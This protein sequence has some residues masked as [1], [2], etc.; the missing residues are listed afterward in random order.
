M[1]IYVNALGTVTPIY[2]VTVYSQI[3]GRVMEVHYRE[4]QMVRKGDSLIDIDPRPYQATLKQA[5]GTLQH[6]EGL[7]AQARMDLQRYRDAYSRNAIAKQQ[8]DDQVQT[9]VQYEGT[10]KADQGSVAYD[11]VQLEYCHIVAPIA[12]RVGLRLVD[13]GNTVF[14]GGGSA[15]VVITQLQPITVVFNVSEDDLPQVQA[16]LHGDFKLPVDAFD[17]SNAHLIESGTLASLDNEVDTTTGTVRFRAEFPNSRL[18]LFPNQFVNARLLVQMLKN[19]ALVP[20]AAIQHNGTRDFVYVVESGNTVAV[21]NV[22]ALTSNEQDTAV[23]GLKAGVTIATTGFDR[24]ENGAHVTVR[25][26][27]RLQ[28]PTACTSSTGH[29]QHHCIA[30]SPSRP[31]IIRPVATALLMVAV[32]LG[33]MVAYFQLPVSALPEVDYPTIQVLTF[34]PGASPS[35]VATSVTAPLERQFGQVAGLGQMTSTSAGGVSA[36]V[37]EFQLSLSID[38]AE[39]EVQAAINAA[40]SYLPANLPTPPVYS[41]SNPADAPV[42]TLALTSSE[43]PL[44]QVED[45]ADTRL[46]PKI[47]QISG[48]GLVSISGGQKPAVRIQAN[49]TALASYGINL[50]DLRSAV[51][52]NSLNAAKGNFDGPAQDYTINANDQLLTSDTYKSVVV[53]YRQGAPIM[54]SD[55]AHIVDSVE[56]D[57]LAAWQNSIPAVILNIQRQPGA[58][59]ISVVD[60]IRKLLP[61]LESTLPAGNSRTGGHRPHDLHPRVSSRCRV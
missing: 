36:I 51:A 46:A 12:G 4:G 6:D 10:V 57:K 55:V 41:K 24:L 1:G 16:Q 37:M 13:P 25:V 2:T 20:T 22:T 43:L 30:M 23:R 53:A 27:A 9:V 40:Q 42:L 28:G 49:P 38:V 59:T 48:V 3:T 19:V 5:R 54:L 8:L 21:Q 18:A 50:E 31:F 34:Y 44:S 52:G 35:V 58:N 60:N 47:S 17:R 45:L 61:Q 26:S 39:Q 32:L 7:L 33:G 29:R 14:A 56:N 11:E 15:L